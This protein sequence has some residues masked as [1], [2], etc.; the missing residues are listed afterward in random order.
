MFD[1]ERELLPGEWK[2]MGWPTGVLQRASAV[3]A[4]TRLQWAPRIAAKAPAAD[5]IRCET[6][7]SGSGRLRAT[8]AD[9]AGRV[10]LGSVRRSR[11][12]VAI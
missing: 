9:G 4:T 6:E 1:Q 7:P 10:R 8:I 3:I 2:W 11:R 5:E 12:L